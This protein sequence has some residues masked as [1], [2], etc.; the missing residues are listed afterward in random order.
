[1]NR[2]TNHCFFIDANAQTKLLQ[3]EDKYRN[4]SKKIKMLTPR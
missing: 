3:N 2:N 1:M 4:M